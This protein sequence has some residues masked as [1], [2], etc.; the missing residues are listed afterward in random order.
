VPLPGELYHRRNQWWWRVQLPGED[1][2]TA[3]PLQVGGGEAPAEGRGDAGADRTAAEKAALA[4]WEQAIEENATRRLKLESTEKVERLKAQFLDKVRH[5]TEL[6]EATNAKL[7]VEQRARAE[8]EA[9]LA[10]MMQTPAPMPQNTGPAAP[11]EQPPAAPI[12]TPVPVV[13]KVERAALEMPAPTPQPPTT[14]TVIPIVVQIP[15]PCEHAPAPSGPTGPVEPVV[16]PAPVPRPAPVETGMCECC[17]ATGIAMT[18][19][20]RID[21]GQWLCPRCLAALRADATESA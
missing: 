1:K 15:S 12:P 21:S 18:H 14:A 10:R 7:E 2:A 20:A 19:L 9:R 4:M 6:V 17:G 8:T 16:A 3:R 5:F 13:T 11:V